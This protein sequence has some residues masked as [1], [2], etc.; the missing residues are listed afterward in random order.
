MEYDWKNLTAPL[1]DDIRM[2][3]ENGSWDRELAAID[4]RLRENCR[5]R[6]ARDS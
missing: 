1:P 4:K 5:R 6:C 2:L 3:K